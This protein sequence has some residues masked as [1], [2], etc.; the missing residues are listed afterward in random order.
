M[1]KYANQWKKLITNVGN[2]GDLHGRNK[3]RTYCTFKNRYCTENY[4]S[5][6]RSKDTRTAFTRLRISAHNLAIETGRHVKPKMKLEER[7]CIN[8]NHGNVIEDEYHFL[9]NCNKYS[10]CRDTLFNH[11]ESICPAFNDLNDQEKFSFLMNGNDGD[12]EITTAVCA[13]VKEAFD[14]RNS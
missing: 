10:E 11:V 5:M 3:L 7:V 9:M 8:C 14:M 6:I 2:T 12:Y 1:E 13:F 4:L